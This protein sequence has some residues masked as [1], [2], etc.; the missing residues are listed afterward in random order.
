MKIDYLNS[1]THD[2]WEAYVRHNKDAT[3]YHRVAWKRVFEESFGHEA[4]YLLAID[5]GLVVGILPII[6]LKS[7]IFGRMLCSITNTASTSSDRLLEYR[8]SIRPPTRPQSS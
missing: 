8:E 2:L 3:F 1:D 6:Q 4:I 7:F 5:N